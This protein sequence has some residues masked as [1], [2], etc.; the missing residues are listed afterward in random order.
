LFRCHSPALLSGAAAGV[1][2]VDDAE[3]AAVYLEAR[4]RCFDDGRAVVEDLSNGHSVGGLDG[5]ESCVATF[6]G[7]QIWVGKWQDCQWSLS[8]LIEVLGVLQ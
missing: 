2:V 7:R 5:V 6:F 4:R 1:E 3:A 8:V